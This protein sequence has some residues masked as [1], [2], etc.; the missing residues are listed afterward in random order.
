M[1]KQCPVHAHIFKIYEQTGTANYTLKRKD[2]PCFIVFEA[3]LD[4]Y[5]LSYVDIQRENKRE[6]GNIPT[7]RD[8]S[9]MAVVAEHQSVG[10][11]H[12]RTEDIWFTSLYC[13]RESSTITKSLMCTD[14]LTLVHTMPTKQRL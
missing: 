7:V 1:K 11:R 3:L 14:S 6:Y 13:L 8:F 9:S 10:H 4:G 12:S 2:F 5:H